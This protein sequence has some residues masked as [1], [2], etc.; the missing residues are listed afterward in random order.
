MRLSN[1]SLLFTVERNA[2][3]H[4][5]TG[6]GFAKQSA[7]PTE[8]AVPRAV[9]ATAAT[10]LRLIFPEMRSPW[11][12]SSRNATSSSSD[13]SPAHAKRSATNQPLYTVQLGKMLNCPCSESAMPCYG[14]LRT[15][16]SRHSFSLTCMIYRQAYILKVI[17]TGM[18]GSNNTG[19]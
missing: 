15:S 5:G 2:S 16:Q 13:V 4:N 17:R 14:N 12:A 7:S 18:K 19:T 11:D 3:S 8:A 1:H 10:S 9:T 6:G